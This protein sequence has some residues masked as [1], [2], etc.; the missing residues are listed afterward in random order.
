M[1]RFWFILLVGVPILLVLL[2]SLC[3]HI[4]AAA[5]AGGFDYPEYSDTGFFDNVSNLLDTL[6]P[7]MVLVLGLAIGALL[8][9]KARSMF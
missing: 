4:A 2:C 7:A 1:R 6:A 8:L 5:P 9:V 3:G